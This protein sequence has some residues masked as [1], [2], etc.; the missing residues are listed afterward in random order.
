MSRM[1]RALELR[2]QVHMA[3]DSETNNDINDDALGALDN[4]L[5]CL[6]G[7]MDASASVAHYTLGLQVKERDA[8][9][10]N[11]GWLKQVSG[12]CPELANI[13]AKGSDNRHTLTI[14]SNMRNS[15]HGE[16]IHGITKQDSDKTETII[17]LPK[18]KEEIVL[19]SMNALGGHASWGVNQLTKN[20]NEV[21]PGILVD[22]IFEE[23]VA[24]LNDIMKSTPIDR[25][26]HIEKAN[27][28]NKL[29][30]DKFGE[31]FSEWNRTTIR[32][33]LGF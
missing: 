7:A 33:Q 16:P 23:V 1:Q 25:L 10:Q 31:P 20:F 28:S 32:W 22:R 5:I 6:M 2:D 19:R 30:D 15:I 12:V 29:P 9:W 27:K 4:F 21:N 18:D 3:I 26:S 24:L 13:F 8:A 11:D 14:L 17:A